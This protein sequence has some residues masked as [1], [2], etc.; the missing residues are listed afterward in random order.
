VRTLVSQNSLTTERIAEISAAAASSAATSA[1][2][3]ARGQWWNEALYPEKS[4][5]NP[6]GDK[7]NPRPKL[8]RDVLWIGYRLQEEE[9]QREEI[10]LLNQL[11]PGY[12]PRHDFHGMVIPNSEKFFSVTDMDPGIPNGRLL[13]MFPCKEQDDRAELAKYDRGRGMVDILL[14]MVPQASAAVA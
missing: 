2:N 1:N 7:A 14:E 12:Y 9:L 8:N 10:N 3:T 11:K 13:V 6:E 5:F 4:V